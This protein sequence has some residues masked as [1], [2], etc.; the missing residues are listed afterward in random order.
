[1]VRARKGAA[2]RQAKRRLFKLVKG[3]RGGKKNLLRT[4]KVAILRARRF[5][6]RDRRVRRRE[7]RKLWILR[8]N[9]AC[10]Q[11]GTRY[12]L[13]IH[14]LAKAGVEIDRKMLAHLA[15]VDPVAFDHLVTIAS[16]AKAPA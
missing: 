1:M 16:G 14:G 2:V 10:R 4:L 11:R 9:A 8:I 15:V 7:F 6:Y 3:Y 13:F 12:N 5:A